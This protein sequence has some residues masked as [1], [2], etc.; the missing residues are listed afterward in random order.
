[1]TTIYRTNE[2]AAGEWE[3]KLS[4]G[5]RIMCKLH[6]CGGYVEHEKDANGIWWIGLRCATCR[7][8]LDPIKSNFQDHE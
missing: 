1:M 6:L 7:K 5:R 4:L 8:F 2:A 3:V